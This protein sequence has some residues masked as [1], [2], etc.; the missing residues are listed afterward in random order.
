MRTV[1]ESKDAEAM[2]TPLRVLHPRAEDRRLRCAQ[3]S[4]CLNVAAHLDWPAMS[5][6]SCTGYEQMTLS[7]YRRDME[8]LALLWQAL[9]ELGWWTP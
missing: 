5:C 6:M 1:H 2:R 8:G 4:Y 7:D 3:Q 9:L